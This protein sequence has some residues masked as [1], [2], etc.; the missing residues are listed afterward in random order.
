MTPRGRPV[1]ED[2]LH[3]RLDGQLPRDRIEDVDAYLAA[4]P[5]VKARFSDYAAPRAALRLAVAAQASE[6][7]P[8]R[9]GSQ[10]FSKSDSADD[11]ASWHKF[12]RWLACSCWVA[13][14]AGRCAT[15][16]ASSAHCRPKPSL[17]W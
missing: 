15:L 7:I 9:S 1:E 14:A 12:P 5:E 2:D 3:A 6:P 4:H 10:T 17:A 16:S 11:T 8:P 13:S